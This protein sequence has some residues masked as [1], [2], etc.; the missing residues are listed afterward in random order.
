MSAIMYNASKKTDT[1]EVLMKLIRMS[2]LIEDDELLNKL[3]K[4]WEKV[5][6]SIKKEFGTEPV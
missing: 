4:I 6:N 5:N 1:Q 2:F 3:N